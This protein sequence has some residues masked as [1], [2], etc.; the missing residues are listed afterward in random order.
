MAESTEETKK[1][2]LASAR[3][4]FLEKG[5]SGAS[6]RTIA[7][8][9]AL[10]T[11]A[12][13][14]HF[15]DKNALFCALVDDAVDFSTKAIL[16]SGVEFH[17]EDS[18]PMSEA[19]ANK[20]KAIL[21]GVIDY[22]Y[23]NFDAFVLLLTKSAGSTHENFLQEMCDLYTNTVRETIN[24]MYSQNIIRKNIDDMT[25]HITANIFITSIAEIVLHKMTKDEAVL[26]IENMQEF[27]H[28]GYMH[29]MGMECHYS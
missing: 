11:G 21:S 29:M 16:G 9:A 19:H 22:I 7:A 3:I 23:A 28:F 24:H 13:Y 14:R 25:V 10:T 8:N 1:K 4:E 15:K 26:F 17:K 5:F 6:L 27:Y 18:D 20:E 2:I 12:M